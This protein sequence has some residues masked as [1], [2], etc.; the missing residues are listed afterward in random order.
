MTTAVSN[1]YVYLD[2][3]ATTPLCDEARAAME[4]YLVCGKEALR[5]GQ[6]NPNSLHSPG[7]LAFEQLECLRKRFAN[8]VHASRPSEIIFTGGATEADNTALIGIA[9]AAYAE[10][11]RAGFKGTPTVIT[12]S[13]E[14]EAVLEAAKYLKAHN[15]N[16]ITLN[17]NAQG[18]ITPD[19]LQNVIDES[20]VLVSIQSANSEIG[21]LQPIEALAAIAHSC[22]A[23]FHTDAVQ[24]FG[25][26]P[27]NF[28]E[29]AVDAASFA[30]H[31]VCGPKGV[32]ALYVRS[33]IPYNAYLLG[34]GQEGARRSGT[35]NLLGIAG[36]VAAAEK[37][38]AA[39]EEGELER[40]L[41]M[42]DFLYEQLSK[43]SGV[44]ATTQVEPLSRSYLPNIV[45]VLVKGFESETLVLRLDMKGFGVSGGS[46]CASHSL[47]PSHVLVAMGVSG[48]EALGS[49]RISFGRYTSQS[50]VEAFVEA[51]KECV[52]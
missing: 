9:S 22:K 4:P 30:A 52:S 2:W 6:A 47:E 49:L 36:F 24:A 8:L 12:S 48:D 32:G 31:K 43:I 1:D 20:V 51:L 34:G 28:A 29:S 50:D 37:A 33:R 44:R 27:F 13:I 15:Y 5:T 40:Q 26:I 17:P 18:F 39:D 14:H 42:R 23:Y 11:Q 7:R 46:A 41:H 25:K 45:H 21:S 38:V 16:V 35:Q 3:A 19:S 10:K